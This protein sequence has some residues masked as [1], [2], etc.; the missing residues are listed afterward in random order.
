MSLFLAAILAFSY[1]P[2]DS[3]WKLVTLDNVP[4]RA[5]LFA[6]LAARDGGRAAVDYASM[7]E[8]AGR[9]GE[10]NRLYD[11]VLNTSS[12]TLLINWIES[13]MAGSLPVDTL[14]IISARIENTG[15]EELTDV[16]LKMPLPRSH[17][18]Y[19]QLETVGGA[20]R[21]NDRVLHSYVHS[22]P[23]GTSV[24]L[25][26]V[27]HVRQQPHT[28]RPL[29]IQFE[30]SR[31][32]VTLEDLTRMLRSISVP[33]SENGP[34][35][36]LEAAMQ[37]DSLAGLMGLDLTVTG[38]LL[39]SGG[40]LDFHAWNTVSGADIPFDAVM[41]QSDSMRGIGH[42]PTDFIPLWNLEDTEGHELSVYYPGRE[43]EIS[44][45]VAVSYA[46]TGLINGLMNI[47]PM[48]LLKQISG[49]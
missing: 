15:E 43:R 17:E 45:H 21:E 6:Q 34:G 49:G 1:S 10:A 7:L 24:V 12:D 28:F 30:G 5:I 22:L 19:Q 48:S 37:A 41:F 27:L 44:I 13:R 35:P 31:G 36:C 47:F 39:R 26:L 23:G 25:P 29:P 14:I 32:P 20:F 4:E 18:P 9:F 11:I 38:G 2:Q 3:C 42:C 16:T 8:L 46:D 40:S 33:D